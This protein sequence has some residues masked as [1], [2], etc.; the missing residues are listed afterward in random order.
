M[1]ERRRNRMRAADLLTIMTVSPQ[2]MSYEKICLK[3]NDR[4]LPLTGIE[5]IQDQLVFLFE[6]K[7]PSISMRD[8][9]VFLMKNRE[10]NI[11]YYDGNEKQPV[12]GIKETEGVLQI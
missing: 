8:V 5:T 7:K 1:E 11:C 2:K 12:Y 6:E 9:M 10:K 3:K 4:F